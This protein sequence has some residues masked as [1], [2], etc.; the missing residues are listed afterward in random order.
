MEDRVAGSSKLFR[1]NTNSK[2]GTSTI[3]PKPTLRRTETKTTPSNADSLR[4]ADSRTGDALDSF[5]MALKVAEANPQ[6]E[7]SA[8]TDTNS[9]AD[10]P[11]QR[12]RLWDTNKLRFNK[13]TFE[14][15]K[16]NEEGRLTF[17]YRQVRMNLFASG[18]GLLGLVLQIIEVAMRRL[19]KC[20]YYYQ[21]AVVRTYDAVGGRTERLNDKVSDGAVSLILR[22][23]ALGATGTCFLLI[24]L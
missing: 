6:S 8:H 12:G 3:V 11:D 2:I 21:T 19:T 22:M 23:V 9:A 16:A 5:K 15:Q 1:K 4:P 14:A 18:F 17:H 24:V 10:S 13:K 20:I 7:E